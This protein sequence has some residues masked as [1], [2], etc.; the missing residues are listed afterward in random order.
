MFTFYANTVSSSA[1]EQLMT[2][3]SWLSPPDGPS[4]NEVAFDYIK[5]SDFKVVWS[6]GI[7]GSITPHGLIHF[8]P[9]S[10]RNAIPR[11]QVYTLI[12]DGNV[13]M[14]GPENAEKQISRGSIVREMSCDVMMSVETAENVAKW[15]LEQVRTIR[16]HRNENR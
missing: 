1:L 12:S 13:G 11:R 16:D 2:D 8:A 6:D 3:D 5:A 9:F 10:E 15:L 7:I 14:L 4:K